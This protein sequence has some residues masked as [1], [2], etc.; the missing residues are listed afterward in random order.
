MRKG[1]D[2]NVG[3]FGVE[4]KTCDDFGGGKNE[5]GKEWGRQPNVR[6]WGR[7]AEG[8]LTFAVPQKPRAGAQVDLEAG[9]TASEASREASEMALE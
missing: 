2:E 7:G 4:E 9:R 6:A 3:N 8:G 5:Q 1:T